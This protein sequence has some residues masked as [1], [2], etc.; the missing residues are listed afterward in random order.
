M[1][2]VVLV[3]NQQ[4]P[5]LL[6]IYDL[7]LIW[8][9]LDLMSSPFLMFCFSLPDLKSTGTFSLWMCLHSW[10]ELLLSLLFEQI[11]LCHSLT[12]R[13]FVQS[14]SFWGFFFFLVFFFFFCVCVYAHMFFICF[15]HHLQFFNFLLKR[16]TPEG[17]LVLQHLL[18]W[19]CI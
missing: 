9:C 12:E 3:V 18:Q 16:W 8:I 13:C 17:D 14:L 2:S 7:Y 5:S 4:S 10:I 1:V 11:E 6:N 15:K 19:Y